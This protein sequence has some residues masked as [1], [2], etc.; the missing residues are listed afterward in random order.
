MRRLIVASGAAL[1]ATLLLS[2]ALMMTLIGG[3]S[4]TAGKSTYTFHCHSSASSSDTQYKVTASVPPSVQQGQNFTLGG[5]VLTGTPPVPLLIKHMHVVI[6]VSPGA[7]QS[8][9]SEDVDGPGSKNPPGPVAQPGIPNSTS[10]VN[11]VL[12]GTGAVGT[13]IMFTLQEVSSIVV[14]PSNHAQ[15]LSVTCLFTS[16]N[17]FGTTQVIA[18]HGMR[19]TTAPPTTVGSTTT[20]TQPVTSTTMKHGKPTTTTLP[21]TTTTACSKHCAA[22]INAQLAGY[23]QDP[24]QGGAVLAFWMLIGAFALTVA[25]VSRRARARR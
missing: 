11:F 5:F 7:D 8:S 20:T 17:A 21:N 4:A 18:K 14:D 15:T 12:K 10:P 19:T 24:P 2:A 22:T 1:A 23:Q 6:A 25:I 3:A 9:L 13:N 16:G